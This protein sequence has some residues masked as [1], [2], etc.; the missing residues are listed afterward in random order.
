M[1][2]EFYRLRHANDFLSIAFESPIELEGKVWPSVEHYVTAQM[3][4]DGWFQEKIRNTRASQLLRL[5]TR[6]K[7]Q[8]PRVDWHSLRDEAMYRDVITD[9]GDAIEAQVM[10]SPKPDLADSVADILA[11][12]PATFALVGTSYGGNLALEIA[13]AAPERVTAL[14]LMGCDPAAPQ[15]GHRPGLQ[16][17]DRFFIGEPCQR[18]AARGLPGQR[19]GA[20]AEPAGTC[21]VRGQAQPGLAQ[22]CEPT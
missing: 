21:A 6:I 20:D 7:G 10:L 13:L 15:A 8:F 1:A 11:R 2:I 16:P 18:H 5:S 22:R 14:W 12:A 3:F 17:A 9:L 4:A 19:H